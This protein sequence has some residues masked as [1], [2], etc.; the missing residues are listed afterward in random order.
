MMKKYSIILA[1]IM[2]LITLLPVNAVA[3]ETTDAVYKNCDFN[4]DGLINGD[5]VRLLINRYMEIAVNQENL[6]PNQTIRDNIDKNGDV[7][8]DG[9][10]NMEDAR[11]LSIYIRDNNIKGDVNCDGII[12]GRD[13]SLVL[14]YYSRHAVENYDWQIG[15]DDGVTILGDFDGN[16]IID[17]RDASKILNYYAA[18]S[19]S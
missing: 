19:V 16:D 1:A 13:A 4:S 2:S 18:N 17:A 14:A 5:D 9:L 12:D 15:S 6:L 3:A 10:I 8:K 11:E 7:Y